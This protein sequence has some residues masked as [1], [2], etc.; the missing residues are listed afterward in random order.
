M[1]KEEDTRDKEAWRKEKG[2]RRRKVE[3]KGK[4]EGERGKITKEEKEGRG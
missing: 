1:K 4:E 2:G 3:G